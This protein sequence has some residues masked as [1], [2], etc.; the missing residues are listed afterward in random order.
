MEHNLTYWS[1]IKMKIIHFYHSYLRINIKEMALIAILFAVFTIIKYLTYVF[2]KGPLN[3]SVEILFWIIIGLIFGPFKGSVFAFFCDFVFTFFTTGIAYWMIEYAIMPPLIACLSW[4]FYHFYRENKKSVLW[5][6]LGINII[7]I[8]ASIMV[9]SFQLVSEFKYEDVKVVFPWIAWTLIIFLNTTIFG[10]NLFCIISFYIK[11]EWK[12]IKWLYV[13]SLIILVVVIFRWLWGPYAFIAYLQRFTSKDIIFSKQYWL[14]L[15]GIATKS[16][17]T[18][19]IATLILVPLIH[20]IDV[21][22]K[23]DLTKY[24]YL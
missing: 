15:S 19:P 14:T 17:L 9:F 18:I 16:F 24:E 12:F 6:A 20:I 2:F 3:F 5:I 22:K 21:N 8:A 4:S 7:L 13:F 10:F 11:K 23:H 1:I